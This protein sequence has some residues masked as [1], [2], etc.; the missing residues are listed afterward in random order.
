VILSQNIH[1]TIVANTIAQK[2]N[3]WFQI[4]I[5]RVRCSIHYKEAPK[6]FR[7]PKPQPLSPLTTGA[8]AF[9]GAY[10]C[11][12]TLSKTL[13]G[14][15]KFRKRASTHRHLRIWERNHQIV[16][17]MGRWVNGAAG[18]KWMKVNE[19]AEFKRK[20]MNSR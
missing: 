20:M 18:V 14:L 12:V 6:R 10:K 11:R 3:E 9:A 2:T 1:A 19:G 15:R 8:A 7:Y 17:K 4:Q 5:V 13:H 16:I